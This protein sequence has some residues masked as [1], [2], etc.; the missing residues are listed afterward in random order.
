VLGSTPVQ[1]GGGGTQKSGSVIPG[2]GVRME[3]D[4]RR[5]FDRGDR[6]RL[7]H[8]LQPELSFRWVPSVDQK[9]IPLTDQWAR[10]GSQTQFT[11]SLIQRLLRVVEGKGPFELAS[12][13]LEWAVDVSGKKTAGESP[14]LDP[15]SPYVRALRDQIDLGA[16]RIARDREAASDVFARFRVNPAERWSFSGE[17]LYGIADRNFTTAAVGTEWKKDKGNHALLE[18][19]SSRDLSEDVHCLLAFRPFQLLGFENDVKYSVRNGELTEGSASIRIYPRSDCW[20]IGLMAGH[21][22]NPDEN[23]F[24]L[25]F[26]LKGIGTVGN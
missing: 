8:L 19:R 18:Y 2:G 21:R 12:L 14:Y 5:D 4:F 25:L 26:S 7:V 16:G 10:V 24:K 3:A 20:N 11:F 23:T 6:R 9:D 22:A 17:A 15:L 13:S 1:D